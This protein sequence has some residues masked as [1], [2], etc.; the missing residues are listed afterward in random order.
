MKT[1]ILPHPLLL[2]THTHPGAEHKPSSLRDTFQPSDHLDGSILSSPA[3]INT[4]PLQ[5]LHNW[6]QNSRCDI[7]SAKQRRITTSLDLGIV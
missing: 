4:L 6:R 3:L 7:T 2:H 1:A 5:G